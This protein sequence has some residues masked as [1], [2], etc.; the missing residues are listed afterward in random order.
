MSPL[1]PAWR[2]GAPRWLGEQL[3]ALT[4]F[5][6][7]AVALSWP[8]IAHFTTHIPPY[9]DAR[10]NLWVLWH[11]REWLAG[12]QPLFDLPLLYYP[13]GASLLT[14]GLGP[15][16]GFFALPFWPLG[17][18]AAHNG[19][20]LVSLTLTGYCMYLLAR[21]LE[22]DW[23]VAIFSGALLLAAPLC[24]AG[25]LGHMT[26]L[27]LGGLP[28]LILALRRALNPARSPWWAAAVGLAL[29]LVLLHAG[30]QFVMGAL[31]V[32]FFLLAALARP[33]QGDRA[34][35]ARRAALVG[36]ACLLSVGPLLVAIVRAGAAL[37][38]GDQS[39]NSDQFSPDLLQFL[40]PYHY[41][42]LFG[43]PV[44]AL[45]DR[46]DIA[47]SI[48]AAVWLPWPALALAALAL[49]ARRPGVGRWGWLLA[50]LVL[51]SLG[52]TLRLAGTSYD[53]PLPYDALVR[54]PG[55]G[56]M[57]VPG[58][59]MFLG[60]VALSALAGLGLGGLRRRYPAR[61]GALLLGA[62]SLSLLL[63]WPRPWPYAPTPPVP[64]FYKQLAADPAPYGVF[65]LPFTDRSDQLTFVFSYIPFSSYAQFYQI[66]HGKGIAAGYL[67]RTYDEHPLFPELLNGVDLAPPDL[68]LDGVPANPLASAEATLARYGYRY[69][70]AH[71]RQL[72]MQFGGEPAFAEELTRQFIAQA[73]GDRAPIAR[74]PLADAYAVDPTAPYRPTVALLRGWYGR[75]GGADGWRW[76]SSPARLYVAAERPTAALL[77]LEPAL[78]HDP[79]GPDGLGSEGRLLITGAD[80]VSTTVA[81]RQNQPVLV[82]I[83]LPAGGGQLG[84]A[85]EAGNFRPSDYGAADP[86]IY[87]LAFRRIAVRTRATFG[88]EPDLLLNGAPQR[89]DR[90]GVA[91]AFGTG[92][93][94]FEH[95][96]WRWASSQAELL[97][98]SP[99][100]RPARLRLKLAALYDQG[101]QALGAGPGVM[102]LQ[103]AA[104]DGQQREARVTAGA[105]A[106]FPVELKAGW[107]QLWLISD[108]GDFR[109][110]DLDPANGDTRRLSFVLAGLD[111]VTEP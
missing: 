80:G 90:S 35:V 9:S 65:D 38:G 97:V 13:A 105:W 20:V 2:P 81:L 51:L 93:Y 37:A 69:I 76:A 34:F 12:R 92:W 103:A 41:S 107:N 63:I 28:L 4:I 58:R 17:P 25:V 56:F 64:A 11:V 73:L 29:L 67:S 43:A 59:L 39:S 68:L 66:I 100:A 88:A 108:A 62:A 5:A 6:A 33:E 86:S 60:F 45:L 71:H 31:A 70:V 23:A 26:K 50:L 7:L 19:A 83:V 18:A 101:T 104:P 95:N 99:T 1:T 98:F 79:R 36:A 89:E 8:L 57:R 15:V 40:L 106:E 96:E 55:L 14:H 61:R 75:Y 72:E 91:L 10:H 78:I 47:A 102:R 46:L 24:L 110:I 53:L 32:G 74:E 84:L 30:Y 109:P 44:L 42:L 48:E 54:L 85:L 3:G 82:P 21:D 27:F 49:G 77:E 111:L 52:P 94:A 22:L 87:S 16:T